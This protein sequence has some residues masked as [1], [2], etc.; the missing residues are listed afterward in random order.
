MVLLKRFLLALLFVFTLPLHSANGEAL[1]QQANEFVITAQPAAAVREGPGFQHK[2]VGVLYYGA[3]IVLLERSADGVWSRVQGGNGTTGWVR[4]RFVRA[5]LKISAKPQP[6]LAKPQSQTSSATISLG[7]RAREIFLRGQQL[8]NRANV[9]SKVGDSLTATQPFLR[10]FGTGGYALGQHA[11]LQ[12]TVEFFASPPRE[13]IANSFVNSS[14]AATLAF[15]AAAAL[16]A[17]WTLWTDPDKLCQ[18]NEAPIVCEYRLTKPSVAI[19]LLGPEDMQIYDANTFR[20]HLNRVVQITIDNGVIPVLTTYPNDPN[21]AKP[22]PAAQFNDVIREIA[23]SQDTPLIELRESA[24][25]LP[26]YGVKEDGFHLSDF[27]PAY[28]LD[29]DPSQ[30]SGCRLRNFLTLK[31]LD[32]LRREVLSR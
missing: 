15:N 28:G 17:S 21:N 8:G 32:Q 5:T 2:S 22:F 23:F 25:A 10:Q 9:F 7:R 14:R 3:K 12:P 13:G 19:I 26:Q 11:S 1:L 30:W 4:S 27:G 24:M 6:V 16:D 18:P 31:M 29:G 20:A